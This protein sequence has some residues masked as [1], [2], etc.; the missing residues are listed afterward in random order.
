MMQS[1]SSDNEVVK[2][3][4]QDAEARVNSMMLLYDRLYRTENFSTLSLREYLPPLLDQ[5]VDIFARGSF[6]QVKT[7]LEEIHLPPRKLYP[8]GIILNELA[9]NSLKHAYPS[10]SRGIINVT[11]ARQADW[12]ELVYQDDGVGIAENSTPQKNSGF[13]LRLVQMLVKQ[14]GATMQVERD[15]GTRITLRFMNK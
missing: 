13:G 14:I 10:H 3:A 15:S 7:E 9:T 4:L 12:V 6:I 1:E 5:V 2:Q 11:A 8:L